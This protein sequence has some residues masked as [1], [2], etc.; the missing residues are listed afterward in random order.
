VSGRATLRRRAVGAA[1]VEFAIVALL[2]LIPLS[3]GI[4]QTGLLYV[5]KHT[6]RHA[7]FLAARAGAVSHGSRDEMRRHL[8]KG[9]VPLY[10][11]AVDV[12]AANAWQVVSSAY[13]RAL[14][15][16]HRPDRL[17][18]SVLNPTPESFADFEVVREG[19][20]QIPN[21]YDGMRVG[22]QSGQTLADAN[23]LKIRVEYCA[24]LAVPFV[25]R[26]ITGTLLRV[27]TEPFRLQ[28][29]LAR[30]VPIAGY[31]TVQMHTPARRAALGGLP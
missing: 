1:T 5:A 30:R 6:V 20:R 31:A 28:C 16:A 29:Y 24:P 9:L 22:P 2:A 3:M 25:D 12:D 26:L 8:A 10:A 7:A 19:V 18:L 13:V 21:F 14:A 11:G 27:D 4:L 23:V 15:D 17:R